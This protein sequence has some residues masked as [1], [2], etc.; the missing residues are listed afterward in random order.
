MKALIT[1][2]A[3]FIG[4]HLAEVCLAAGDEVTVLDDLSTGARSNLA[5]AERDARFHFVEGS[6]L[7]EK[8]VGEL[9]AECELVYHLAAAVGVQYVIEHPF[10]C[11]RTNVTGTEIVMAAAQQHGRRTLI[12]SSSEIYGKQTKSPLAEEDDRILGPTSTT[13]WSY[14]STKALDE[15][16]ALAYWKARGL[17]VVIVR[18]FNVVGPR[19]TGRYGMVLPR[20]CRQALK[21][22]PLTVYGDGK[23]TRTF[24]AVTDAAGA[25]RELMLRGAAGGIYNLGG[26]EEISIIEL[27][28]RVKEA[29]GSNSEIALVPYDEAY[30]EGGFEEMPR[31]VP[32][33][34][35]VKKVI[36]YAPKLKLNAMIRGV[37]EW[38]KKKGEG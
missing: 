21:G 16:L 6:I 32:D 19:Q 27:A 1:G 9:T 25:I 28:G 34:A 11:I 10:E 33:L 31:R 5:T 30:A 26:D 24:C 2:G 12:T 23:Q 36:G 22:E 17:P 13:R 29:A 4:S 20:F 35:R 15:F 8:L 3:G 14:A 37:L 7:D 18:L 38:A